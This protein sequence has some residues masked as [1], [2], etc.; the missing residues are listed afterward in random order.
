MSKVLQH[1]RVSDKVDLT[2]VADTR[3]EC[4]HLM[5]QQPHYYI[6]CYQGGYMSDTRYLRVTYRR[7]TS[8]PT[9]LSDVEAI[10]LRQVQV[11]Q[12]GDIDDS[13]YL[14]IDISLLATIIRKGGNQ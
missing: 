8:R 1:D 11:Q 12:A 4:G 5:M 6:M 3:T 14:F 13:T 7:D 2:L 9:P 10:D